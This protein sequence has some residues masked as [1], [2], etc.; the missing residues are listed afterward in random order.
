MPIGAG[1][2]GSRSLDSETA[3]WLASLR[4]VRRDEA[5]GQLHD[6]LL[7]VAR[8]EIRRRNT[9]GQITGPEVD[10]LAHQAAADAVLLI[11][12]RIDE[13]RGESRF[14]TW[15]Y[16][17]VVFEVSTKLGRHVWNR[18]QAPRAAVDWDL[19]PDRLGTRPADAAELQD[20]IAA[21]RAAAETCLTQRQREVFTAIVV[22]GVPLD[23]LVSSMG[24]TRTAI[25]KVM[26]DARQKL[27]KEL[28]HGGY[29]E[30]V[31]T[32]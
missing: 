15:A 20:L 4:G 1:S 7:R 17:F 14:T 16:K 27:R 32:P 3:E 18:H 24:T 10:D 11:T 30:A 31:E 25:Y 8:S 28:V 6:L 29:I 5:I 13:F 21:V 26:F 9:G 12:N 22:E 19:L 2:A 23:A